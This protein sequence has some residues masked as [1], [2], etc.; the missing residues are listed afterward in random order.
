MTQWSARRKLSTNQQQNVVR[1]IPL[2]VHLKTSS[3]IAIPPESVV[4]YTDVVAIFHYTRL[5]AGQDLVTE[6]STFVHA[7]LMALL[8]CVRSI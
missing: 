5:I 3:F 6:P 7:A 1:E 8:C 2:P 4:F